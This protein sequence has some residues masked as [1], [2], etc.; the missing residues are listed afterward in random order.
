MPKIQGIDFEQVS[1][2]EGLESLLSQ[3]RKTAFYVGFD[4]TASS[5]HVGHL[6]LLMVIRKLQ[7]MGHHAFV[8]MGTATAQIGDPT[9]KSESRRTMTFE[10]VETNARSLEHQISTVCGGCHFARNH[11]WLEDL[12]YL[13]FLREVGSHFSVNQLLATKTYKDRLESGSSLGFAEFNYKLIQAFDFLHLFPAGCVLQIGGNDQWGNMLAGVELIHK[14]TGKTAIAAT[15]PLLTT[16]DGRKMGKT[17]KG[18]V[19][20]DPNRTPPFAYFKF[21]LDCLDADLPRFLDLFLD[22][23]TPGIGQVRHSLSQGEISTEVRR[24]ARRFL[25]FEATKILHGEA[26][27]QKARLAHDQTRS[28]GEWGAVEEVFV[29]EGIRVLDVALLPQVGIFSSNREARARILGGAVRINGTTLRDPSA[30]LP[31]SGTLRVEVGKSCK[32][33]VTLRRPS[34]SG[35]ES[36]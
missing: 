8:V 6:A 17:E 12:G 16:A 36:T 27:A 15:I 22:E 19:W 28:D 26:Q 18:A 1:D 4:P 11:R 3:E 2:P 9:G 25:A 13:H 35:E 10:E 14:K 21:W 24:E 7:K 32:L 23:N 5:L 31:G 29:D 33:R 30:L 20:L 34:R